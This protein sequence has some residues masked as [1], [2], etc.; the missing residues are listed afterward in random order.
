M[1]NLNV[2]L[3]LANYLFVVPAAMSNHLAF[4]LRYI[5]LEGTNMLQYEMIFVIQDQC[6][7]QCNINWPL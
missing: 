7:V 3:L 1:L 5:P 2:N 4:D 6:L